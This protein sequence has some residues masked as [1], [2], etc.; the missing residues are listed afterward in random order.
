MNTETEDIRFKRII[1]IPEITAPPERIENKINRPKKK[2][3]P[4]FRFIKTGCLFLKAGF[5]NFIGL[6]GSEQHYPQFKGQE[7]IT[8]REVFPTFS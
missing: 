6:L 5:R 2:M 1:V 4:K 8:N 7:S 3:V